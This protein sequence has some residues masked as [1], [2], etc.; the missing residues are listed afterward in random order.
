MKPAAIVM[1]T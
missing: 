1:M